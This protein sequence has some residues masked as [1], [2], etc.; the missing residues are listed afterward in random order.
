MN[1]SELRGR[2]R[3]DLHDEDSS[4]YRWADAALDRHIDHA[5]R[6]LGEATP[7]QAKATLQ[8]GAG[9]RELSMASLTGLIAV[10]AV[11][12]PTGLYPPA[13]VPFSLWGGTLTLLTERV[14]SSGEQVNVYYGKAHVVDANGSTA[15]AHLEDLLAMGAEAYAALEW[16]S[17]AT[18]RVNVGGA[19][20]WREYQLWGQERLASFLAGLA[21][22][23]RRNA[24]RVR[25]LYA[26]ALPTGSQSTDWGPG[27]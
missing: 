2:I 18:N 15:P 20:T 25:R 3:K 6:E 5:L 12:Y 7:Q 8:T 24:V 16:A 19:D 26:P 11:E 23:G 27:A 22:H 17:Y 10:E 14:P 13:Y 4:S 9:S 21:R 1:L